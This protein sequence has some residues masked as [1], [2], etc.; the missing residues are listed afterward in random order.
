[1]TNPKISII[2]PYYNAELYLKKC[3]SSILNQ[4]FFDFELILIDDG[5]TDQSYLISQSFAATDNRVVLLR[6]EN[7]GQ[8]T[9]RNY[10]LDYA[11]GEYIGFVD[12]DDY[13]EPDMYEVLYHNCVNHNAELAICGYKVF[14]NI[15][16]APTN[17]HTTPKRVFSKFSLMET[18]ILTPLI[19]SGPCNKLY[20][21][22]LFE[23]VRFPSLRVAED[24]F[25]LPLIF[26]NVKT[27][28][29]VGKSLYNWNLRM[30]STER[31]VFTPKHLAAID[32]VDSLATI[33]KKNY[34]E[35][36]QHLPGERVKV[37]LSILEHIVISDSYAQYQ[38]IYKKLLHEISIEIK[39][40]REFF[41]ECPYI[42]KKALFAINYNLLF[43]FKVRYVALVKNFIKLLISKF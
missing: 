19:S 21:K 6:K 3:I 39:D 9:A 16:L 12:S 34:T 11:K 28:V 5:S 43:R 29:Y 23:N 4:R 26:V 8:G 7:G 41:K 25:V 42:L 20:S 17:L 15:K 14:R 40:S 33:I 27:A 37:R 30:G 10:G 22:V 32:A 31:S 35:L 36:I 13:I 2:V 38:D 1:M 24:A 18:Y